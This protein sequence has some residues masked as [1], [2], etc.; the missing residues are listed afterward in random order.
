MFHELGAEADE[1]EGFGWNVP[2]SLASTEDRA[3]I[4]INTWCIGTCV[5]QTIVITAGCTNSF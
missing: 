3:E 1:V 4:V 2:T 5:K